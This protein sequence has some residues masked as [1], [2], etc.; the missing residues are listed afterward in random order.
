MPFENKPKYV[1]GSELVRFDLDD[2]VKNN[3]NTY[4]DAI[5][6]FPHSMQQLKLRYDQYL[7]TLGPHKQ[8]VAGVKADTIVA[9]DVVKSGAKEE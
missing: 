8:E 7:K 1:D 3:F 5:K 9:F 6:K 2:S 4:Q